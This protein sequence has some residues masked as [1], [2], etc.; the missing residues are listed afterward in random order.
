MIRKPK[1]TSQD[2]HGGV[3]AFINARRYVFTLYS[4]LAVLVIVTTATIT[5]S[6]VFS[7]D[8]EAVAKELIEKHR[9]ETVGMGL[10]DNGGV[11]E[12][13][14]SEGGATWTVLL[15]M[16]NGSSFVVGTG[17]AWAAKDIAPKG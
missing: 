6:L 10:A 14:T 16:P 3:R 4:L 12:L 13:F 11:L 1:L 5:P 8:R 7:M 2:L 9:E 15:T 17:K